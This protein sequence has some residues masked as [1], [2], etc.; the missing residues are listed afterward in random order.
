[1]GTN[2]WCASNLKSHLLHHEVRPE[3]KRLA[4]RLLRGVEHRPG[5]ARLIL[6]RPLVREAE[7]EAAPRAVDPRGKPPRIQMDFTGAAFT[8]DRIFCRRHRVPFR[9]V[10]LRQWDVSEA[11]YF[12]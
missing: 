4:R 1:M 12:R 2:E 3:G 7:G 9:Q 10:M 6:V 8:A 11:T 5:V